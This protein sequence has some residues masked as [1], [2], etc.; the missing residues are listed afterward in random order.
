MSIIALSSFWTHKTHFK[1]GVKFNTTPSTILP[2]YL[3]L[4]QAMFTNK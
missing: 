3:Y 1:R 2:K 4:V